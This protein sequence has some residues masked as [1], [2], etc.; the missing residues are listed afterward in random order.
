MST[1]THEPVT[2]V[3]PHVYAPPVAVVVNVQVTALAFREAD[4]RYSVVIPELPGCYSQGDTIDEVKAMAAD[5]AGG[6][7]AAQHDLRRDQ[8]IRDM[9]EPLPDEGSA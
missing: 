3:E 8:V 2:T 6:W 9:K 7:L 1:A 5:A 4:G